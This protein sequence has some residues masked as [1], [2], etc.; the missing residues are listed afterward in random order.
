MNVP[1]RTMS[2][3]YMHWAKTRS[4]ARFNLASSGMRNLTPAEFPFT[5][6]DVGLSGS[7]YY[8]FPDLQKAL[9]KHAG[10][11]EACVFSSIGT[12][13]ANFVAM[14]ALIEPG[15]EV[16]V[17]RPVYDL[18][19]SAAGY[20]QANIKW[21]PRPESLGYQP[22]LDV[23]RGMVGA[24]TKLIVLTNLHN[25]SS[26]YIEPETTR[27]IGRLA[28]SVGARVLVDEVYLDAVFETA[29]QSAF[30]FGQEFVTTNSLTKVYGLS[31]LR[32]GWVLAEP[33][34]I[35]KMW[36]LSDLFNVIPTHAGEL[37]SIRALE[38]LPELKARTRAILDRNRDLVNRFIASRPDL[39]CLPAQ[40]GMTIFPKLKGIGVDVLCDT[41]R[42][43]F[44]TTVV[45]GSFFDQPD[46]FRLSYGQDTPVVEEGLVRVG[47]ALDALTEGKRTS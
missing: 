42:H 10:V 4:G 5:L 14:A 36:R 11:E 47:L 44:E 46:H 38:R 12:S 2:S 45:P 8:G 37:L 24:R 13:M 25:P 27:E 30:H 19:S 33:A 39:E 21:L 20:L 3:P 26:A 43:Q 23:L 9:A 22:D 15:D 40:F 16:L 1:S 6:A 31:G 29:P 35:E 7:S 28:R 41:L 34:L 32:C 17:E 18:I